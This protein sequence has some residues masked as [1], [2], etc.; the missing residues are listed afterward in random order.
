MDATIT[1]KELLLVT[2]SLSC[3]RIWNIFHNCLEKLKWIVKEGKSNC[4]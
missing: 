3:H 2:V 4:R 1:V